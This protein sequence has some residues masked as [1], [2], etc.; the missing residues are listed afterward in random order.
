MMYFIKKQWQEAKD[1]E[2]ICNR[3]E[4]QY[5]QNELYVFKIIINSFAA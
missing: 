5:A 3:G 1:P 2:L 4:L